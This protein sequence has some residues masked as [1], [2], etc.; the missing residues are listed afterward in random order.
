[1]NLPL[2]PPEVSIYFDFYGKFDPA[3]ITKR[4]GIEPTSWCRAGDP[5]L[6]GSGVCRRDRWILRV[7]PAYTFEIDDLLN[8]IQAVVTATPK[9]IKKVSSDLNINP[10]I[11]CEVFSTASMPSLCFSKEFVQ[12]S[13]SIG[14]AIEGDIMLLGED[15]EEADIA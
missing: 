8:Q 5:R 11:T 2:D 7:G 6:S 12:W 9:E 4:L 15:E 14:A 10:V 13:A 1:V 3:E